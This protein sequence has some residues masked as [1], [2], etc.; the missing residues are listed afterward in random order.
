M[1]FR[2]ERDVLADALAT[3]GRAAT[4]R[5]GT[6]PVLSGVRLEVAGD[7]LTVTGTDLE[8]TIR[9]DRRRRRRAR[10]RA[11][12]VPA[13][14]VG[15][16]RPLAAGR[17][18]RGRRWPTTSVSISAG[19]SQ[20]SRAPAV[21]RRL[22]DAGRAGRRARSRCRRRR[23]ARRCARWCGPRA[24]TTP[25]PSSPACCSPPRTTALRMVATD[26]Y[27]LAVRDL[28]DS[29]RA[30]RRPE[31]ARAR[32]GRSTSCSACSA[33]ASELHGAPRRARRDVRGRR[34]PADAPG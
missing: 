23:S 27:R 25:A 22:P 9:L 8:L 2:C 19:R 16:H 31:G 5:T 13:R 24:P 33:T 20:F 10:R 3:A 12:C 11:S 7:E 26:S 18:G 17:R 4:S 29:Q 1:K 15:R 14:L 28:P 6:L 34:H 32:A 21:A 30:R